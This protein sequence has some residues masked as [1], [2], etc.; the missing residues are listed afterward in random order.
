MSESPNDRA[1]LGLL[2]SLEDLQG[3]MNILVG[4]CDD[5]T[6][7]DRTI[8]RYEAALRE[9]GMTPVRTRLDPEEPSITNAIRAAIAAAPELETGE[10]A[11]TIL[12]ADGLSFA[13]RSGERSPQEKFFGYLQWTREALMAFRM[14]LV[15][16][17]SADLANKL[18]FKA[19][20][21]WSWRK[22]V[23]RFERETE[24][25]VNPWLIG[26]KLR[27]TT[28]DTSEDGA[29]S[30]ADLKELI[31]ETE[32]RDA[33][34]PYLSTLYDRLGETYR[35]RLGRGEMVDSPTEI[36]EAFW[37]FDR[38]IELQAELGLTADLVES[39]RHRGNLHYQR[40]DYPRALH[41]YEKSL[42]FAR[43]CS[44]RKGEAKSLGNLGKVYR[45]LGQ[46]ERAIDFQQQSLTIKRELGDRQG[47]ATSLG[48]LGSVYQKLGQYERAIDFHQQSLTIQR[49]LGNRQVEASSIIDFGNVYLCW[50]QYERAI[51]LYQQS[52]AIEQE[53]SNQHGEASSLANLGLAYANLGQYERAINFYRQSLAITEQIGSRLEI[54]IT[55]F[56]LGNALAKTDDRWNA[57]DAYTRARTLYTD[58][59]IDHEVKSCDQALEQLAQV[60]VAIPKRAPR[61][62]ADDDE[63]PKPQPK[64]RHPLRTILHLPAKLWRGFVRLIRWWLAGCP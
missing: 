53:L 61:I 13:A 19:S 55:W 5:A 17:V 39:Y 44:D 21:F 37:A 31:A 36:R 7:R 25:D 38:A 24:P 52:L 32:Q 51:C 35:R 34:S 50:G 6:L 58:M 62:G 56:N 16:W 49:E 10:G 48:N 63:P 47:E 1:Y 26:G 4:I 54:A 28:W 29:L 20:D 42:L 46:Y 11:I 23:F 40:S 27:S 12:G 15:L 8:D 30:L 59:G 14:P 41:D 33:K 18:V 60:T 64:H 9:Q 22:A 43:D 2:V 3:Q 57:R 45:N